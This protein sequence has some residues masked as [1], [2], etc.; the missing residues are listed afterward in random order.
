MIEQVSAGVDWL[1]ITLRRGLVNDA[2]WAQRGLKALEAIVGEGYK[3]ESRNWNG[4]EGF[5]AGG[6]FVGER[7]DSYCIQLAG[8][9]AHTHFDSVYRY[10][11]HIS[12][13][14]VQVTVKFKKMPSTIAK[15]AYR[16]AIAKNEDLP[17]ARRRKL[18]IIVGSDGGDTAYIGSSS[19]D[20]RGRIYNKEVQSED[21]LYT[22]SWRYEVVLKNEQSTAYG[23]VLEAQSANRVQFCSDWVAVWFE[24]RGVQVTWPYDAAHIPVPP[25][26]TLPTDIERKR[27]WLKHQVRPTI[28]YLLTVQEKESILELLGLS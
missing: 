19:S 26:K 20:V 14:D 1:T 25:Q 16:D 11:A 21:P 6:S 24:K 8:R 12:R 17:V 2:L 5:S 13:L 7:E 9:H 10:D 28:S 4:Y 27:N 18:W 22:R 3:L 23:R 15:E